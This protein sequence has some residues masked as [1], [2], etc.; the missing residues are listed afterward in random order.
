[1]SMKK[2]LLISNAVTMATL[3]FYVIRKGIDIV[4]GISLASGLISLAL[5]IYCEVKYGREED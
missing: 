3:S 5:N 2:I 4:L 1:M